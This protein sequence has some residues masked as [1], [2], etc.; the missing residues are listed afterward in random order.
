MAM[1]GGNAHIRW[2]VGKSFEAVAA[3]LERMDDGVMK[4]LLSCAILAFLR[5]SIGASLP[6]LEVTYR[7]A[8]GLEERCARVSSSKLQW[9]EI[10]RRRLEK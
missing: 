5:S 7:N 6:A 9:S 1:A 10:S 2:E 4:T 8:S 3:S